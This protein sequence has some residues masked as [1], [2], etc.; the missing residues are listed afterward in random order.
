MD[1]DKASTLSAGARAAIDRTRAARAEL[2]AIIAG[3]ARCV[4]DEQDRGLVDM[5][6]LAEVE[7]A[8][9]LR[10]L[11]MVG[12]N[13]SEAAKVAKMHRSRLRRMLAR[14]GA[15]RKAG[16]QRAGAGRPSR[17]RMAA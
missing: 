2:D 4:D 13:K 3:F 9:L 14:E 12:G 17:Q 11:E 5:P 10:V 16:G 8:Y 15:E 7:Y 1:M 6:S